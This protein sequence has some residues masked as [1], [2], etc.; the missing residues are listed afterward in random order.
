MTR[1]EIIKDL[2]RMKIFGNYP[3]NNCECNACTLTRHTTFLL[4]E[5]ERLEKNKDL[6]DYQKRNTLVEQLSA[7]IKELEERIQLAESTREAALAY[8][9]MFKRRQR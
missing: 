3:E 5:C 2:E 6:E 4:S 1:D 9:K 7:H 8:A